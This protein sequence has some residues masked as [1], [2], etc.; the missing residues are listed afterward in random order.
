ML[1]MTQSFRPESP[2]DPAVIE[3]LRAIEARGGKDLL[4]KVVAKFAATGPAAIADLRAKL[5][6]GDAEP[7]WRAAHGL[8]S[9]ASVV[10]AVQ[11][12]ARC[13]EIEQIV[14]RDGA[15]AAAA[16]IDRL[17]ADVAIAIERLHALLTGVD[18][19]VR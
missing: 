5:A 15:A 6:A 12:V 4:R 10:G 18:A 19:A 14:R 2:I 3:G 9:S 13:V 17:E 16:A 1:H 7:L 8:K 11:V